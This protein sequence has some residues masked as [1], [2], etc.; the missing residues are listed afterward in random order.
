M[1]ERKHTYGGAEE[2]LKYLAGCG[3]RSAVPA[4]SLLSEIGP[5][6]EEIVRLAQEERLTCLAGLP[7][8]LLRRQVQQDD[9]ADLWTQ[10]LTDAIESNARMIA[11]CKKFTDYLTEKEI[12]F[13]VLEDAVLCRLFD[14]P[15]V[16]DLGSADLLIDPE[17]AEEAEAF[18]ESEGYEIVNHPDVDLVMKNGGEMFRI[19]RWLRSLPNPGDVADYYEDIAVRL[20]E[21]DGSKVEQVLSQEDFYIYHILYRYRHTSRRHPDLFTLAGIYQI[22]T[23]GIGR[24]FDWEHVDAELETLGLTEFEATCREQ[25]MEAFEDRELREY[26]G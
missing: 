26:E 22:L 10:P 13:T 9:G 3:L 1:E 14:W 8:A 25:A 18:L 11:A 4:A 21:A 5:F 19:R 15:A 24:S 16:P 2:M 23:R 17:R 6:E 12:R 7:L 20:Q